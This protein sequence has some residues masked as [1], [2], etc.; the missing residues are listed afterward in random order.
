M[1]LCWLRW[2]ICWALAF[3]FLY[4]PTPAKAQADIAIQIGWSKG[5]EPQAVEFDSGTIETR[6]FKKLKDHYYGE[7]KNLPF[8]SKQVFV[9]RWPKLT[10]TLLGQPLVRRANNE[11]E[12]FRITK[13]NL[14]ML[15]NDS[16]VH[17]LFD[18][19]DATDT[20]SRISTMI[21]IVAL[22]KREGTRCTQNNASAL[23]NLMFQINYKL[24]KDT[25]A[26][27]FGLSPDVTAL[28][29]R[30]NRTK[31][32]DASRLAKYQAE[33]DG[34]AV[35]AAWDETTA[36]GKPLEFA[37]TDAILSGLLEV[38]KDTAFSKAFASQKIREVDVQHRL[39]QLLFSQFEERP[40]VISADSAVTNADVK[41]ANNAL[42]AAERLSAL[43]N[44][45]SYDQSFANASLTKAFVRALPATARR[46]IDE[47]NAQ[48]SAPPRN[49]NS[50]TP[51][52]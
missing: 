39:L 40:K 44:D 50:G 9:I 48:Q 38:S 25:K 19:A 18:R 22:L 37:R 47:I 20:D 42:L 23:A 36:T 10:V 34:L 7:R 8:N 17:A 46:T 26:I 43:S 1:R 5:S 24:A 12:F 4:A 29:L 49:G 28:L 31:S 3:T 15:C 27:I 51:P 13:P 2:A 33:I 6:R 35:K 41:R 45:K 21:Q 32:A 11:P 52:V 30:Y 16:D 14:D